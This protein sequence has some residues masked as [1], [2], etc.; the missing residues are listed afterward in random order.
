MSAAVGDRLIVWR[1]V[2]KS[3]SQSPA[4]AYDPQTGQR[5]TLKVPSGMSWFDPQ[6]SS[7]TLVLSWLGK[8]PAP[9]TTHGL[10]GV[11]IE[12]VVTGSVRTFWPT[13]GYDALNVQLADTRYAFGWMVKSLPRAPDGPAIASSRA[14]VIDLAS[15]SLIDLTPP[16]AGSPPQASV[17]AVANG[18]ALVDVTSGPTG[19][20]AFRSVSLVDL[21]TGKPVPLDLGSAPFG[22]FLAGATLVGDLIVG[23]S[24]TATEVGG[25]FVYHISSGL[26]ER[27]VQDPTAPGDCPFELDATRLVC[28]ED[29][30]DGGQV[31]VYDTSRHSRAVVP[32][33]GAFNPAL[34]TF[35]VRLLGVGNGDIVVGDG[36]GSSALVY[37]AAT[38][39]TYRLEL[40]GVAAPA[41]V[42][43]FGN[44]LVCPNYS[45]GVPVDSR[46]WRLP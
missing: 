42:A 40:G 46:V 43:I 36:R 31:F 35:G 12:D 39:L 4:F 16:D 13:D 19:D 5:W 25:P 23:R 18:R 3:P 20:Y 29:T 26:L 45:Y 9:G 11:A 24:D 27:P 30:T 22:S 15:G 28:Y 2:D 21:A 41:S 38:G 1:N 32:A 37:V 6:S 34:G 8:P 17:G 14:V 7:G 44:L 33:S 10:E